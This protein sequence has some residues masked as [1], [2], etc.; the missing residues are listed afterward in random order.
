[1]LAGRVYRWN[2]GFDRHPNCDCLHIPT[3][4]AH[5]GSYLADPRQLADRGLIH[6]LTRAQRQRLDDGADLARVL[7][8]S[9]DRWREGMAADRRARGPVD[10]LGRS[11]PEGWGGGS[12]P[13][14]VTTIHDLMAHLT[15]RVE[16]LNAMRA[17]GIA[18]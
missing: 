3:T 1:M 13:A 8:E 5:A 2:D 10:A 11:R 15:S 7:N 6:D 12:P 9:R 4:V 14:S 17:A 18:S 16:A